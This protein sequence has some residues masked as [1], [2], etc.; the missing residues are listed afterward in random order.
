MSA[1]AAPRSRFVAAFTERLPTKLAALVLALLLWV[2]VRGEEPREVVMTVRFAP[3]VDGAME[4]VGG[5]PDSVQVV[6]S[7]R[8]RELLKLSTHPPIVRRRVEENGSTRVR[9]VLQPADVEFPLGVQATARE[10]RP[11]AVT[12]RLRSISASDGDR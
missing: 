7:G 10:V 5:A 4:L 9:L 12:L 3:V 6:V 11:S 8:T 1:A 2:L